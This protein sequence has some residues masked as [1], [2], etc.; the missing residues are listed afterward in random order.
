MSRIPQLRLFREEVGPL[1][2]RFKLARCHSRLQRGEVAVGEPLALNL[3][4][5]IR[6]RHSGKRCRLASC[7]RKIDSAA[8]V[9]TIVDAGSGEKFFRPRGMT[10]AFQ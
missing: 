9:V 1:E 2:F 3:F 6:R 8:D 10:T 4:L 5:A 7:S